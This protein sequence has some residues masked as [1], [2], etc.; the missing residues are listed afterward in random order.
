[1]N[2]LAYWG[3]GER[4]FLFFFFYIFY[5]SLLGSVINLFPFALA[6]WVT[7]G[8]CDKKK[9]GALLVDENGIYMCVCVCVHCYC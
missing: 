5:F 1:M 9:S 4:G 3:G 2:K 7:E 8:Q 6:D